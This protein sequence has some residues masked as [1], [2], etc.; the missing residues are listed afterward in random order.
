MRGVLLTS[1][2][3]PLRGVIRGVLLASRG[4]PLR[5]VHRCAFRRSSRGIL[6]PSHFAGST[7][8]GV[9]TFRSSKPWIRFRTCGVQYK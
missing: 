4:V 5:G 9:S 3:V 1:R 6:L 8:V 7:G 2:G